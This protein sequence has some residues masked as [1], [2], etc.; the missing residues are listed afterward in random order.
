MKI[1]LSGKNALV[2][3]A[4]GGIGRAIALQL[5]ACGANVTLL[6]R[7]EDKLKKGERC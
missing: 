2:G 6:A 5:A 4:S 7:N 3:G 1:S